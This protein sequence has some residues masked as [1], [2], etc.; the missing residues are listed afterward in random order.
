MKIDK[1][2]LVKRRKLHKN[3]MDMFGKEEIRRLQ[4]RLMNVWP[5][6]H[7]YFLNGWILRFTN[8]ITARANSVFPLYYTGDLDTIDQDIE[9]VEKAYNSYK[10]P[11]I[12]TIPEFFEPDNLDI[13]LLEHGYQ[14][15]G[16]TT[17][18][19]ICSISDLKNKKINEKFTYFIKSERLKECSQF[20]AEYSHRNQEA[21]N[22]LEAL[23]KR[24]IIPQKR[25]IIAKDENKVIGT[26]A[27]ILDPHGFLYIV[28]VLVHPDFRRQKIAT[29]M[30]FSLISNRGIMNDIQTVWLQV[31]TDNYKAMNLYLNLGFKKAYSYYYLEKTMK[32]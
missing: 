31:E 8:G 11:S 19:M 3:L 29:S 14:Q 17:H 16:C 20:L 4:E 22:V 1:E 13:K 30:F 25:F 32:M 18:T 6:D 28:D 21:Q 27:G 23:S 15:L 10:L 5:A 24:I 2:R 7:Y 26:L 12:F 9:Y